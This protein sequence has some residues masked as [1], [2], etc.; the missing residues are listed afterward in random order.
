MIHGVYEVRK[1]WKVRELENCQVIWV[2]GQGKFFK[3]LQKYK[4][5]YFGIRVSRIHLSNIFFNIHL[6][7]GMDHAKRLTQ[8]PSSFEYL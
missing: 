3:W 1:T 8:V 6:I 7:L 4:E 2:I 5:A